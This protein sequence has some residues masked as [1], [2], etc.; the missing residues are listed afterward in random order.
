[1]LLAPTARAQ[2]D[3]EPTL[4]VGT[5]AAESEDEVREDEPTLGVGTAAAER[6]VDDV[7]D[8]EPPPS[9]RRNVERA[10]GDVDADE[11]DEDDEDDEPAVRPAPGWSEGRV[12]GWATLGSSFGV[13]ILG[14]VLLA[15]GVDAVNRIE[16]AP[17]GTRWDDVAGARDLAPLLTGLGAAVLALGVIGTGVGAGMLAHFGSEGTWI[18]VSVLPGGLALRGTF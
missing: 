13:A 6:P 14:G 16:N 1:M 5:G 10:E 2:E 11:D 7:E 8:G 12:A 4:G 17:D 15:V 3:D 9:A 18:A